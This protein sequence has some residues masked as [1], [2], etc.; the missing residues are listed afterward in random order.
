MT[1]VLRKDLA[2]NDDIGIEHW[3][4]RMGPGSERGAGFLAR[5]WSTRLGVTGPIS[6][7]TRIDA[8]LHVWRTVRQR[9]GRAARTWE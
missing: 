6:E 9:L 1:N 8:H 5:S 7:L 2:V 3:S 4:D